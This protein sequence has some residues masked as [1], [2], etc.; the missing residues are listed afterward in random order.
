MRI[1]CFKRPCANIASIILALM[2]VFSLIPA[3]GY[4]TL[5]AYAET[6]NVNDEPDEFQSEIEQS[7]KKYEEASKEASELQAQIEENQARIDEINETIPNS[8]AQADASMRELYDLN[9][10][11]GMLINTILG[12]ESLS[13][14]IESYNYLEHVRNKN[15]ERINTLSSL[16]QELDDLQ[17]GLSS[18]KAEADAKAQEADAALKKAQ[19]AREEAQ[20]KAQ[21]KAAAEK[22]ALEAALKAE[23]EKKE[24]EEK[25]QQES[26]QKQQSEFVVDGSITSPTK[27]GAD[28]STDKT[29]FVNEWAGRIDNYLAGSPLAGQGKTFAEAAW[30]FGVD[31]RWSPAI[32]NTE[33]SKGLYCFKP[34]N[35]WGW[36][37]SS[38]DSWEEAIR[39]HV[40]GLAN[41]Y[42]YTISEAAAKKYCPPNWLH[43]YNATSAQMNKI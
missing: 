28:W 26:A 7:A 11:F 12:I 15:V 25:Q 17:E 23:Q 38:W 18:K 43:W 30:D 8:Q 4:A 6:E 32:S 1:N 34:H 21:E 27:D 2:L 39:A 40:R 42:G 14:A 16:K 24:Q 41:G 31:P 13:D 19:A 5:T 33:S 22:A 29:T 3:S 35:A 37:S 10:N 9:N 20:R 36:G